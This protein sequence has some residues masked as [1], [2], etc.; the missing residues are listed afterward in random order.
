MN[1]HRR[2]HAAAHRR[3]RSSSAGARAR[4]RRSPAWSARSRGG[5]GAILAL[6]YLADPLSA[7]D[8]AFR[9]FVVLAGLI[10]AV[11]DRRVDRR[12]A[13]S[14]RRAAARATAC[15]GPP[16]G[17]PAPASAPSR[18]CSSCGSPAASWPKARCRAWPRRPADRRPSARWPRSCRPRPRSPSGS[19]AGSTTTGLPDVF[20]GF[21]PLPAAAGRPAGRPD[22]P[23]DRGGRRGQHAQG[24]GRDV[25]PVVGRDRVRRRATA[26]S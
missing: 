19:A 5:V 2:H 10:G 24:L 4:S 11:G 3:R 9:P 21:E 1:P 22:R 20:V 8:P 6:P 17:P 7:I 25:R 18:P 13:R 14:R 12:G 16:T 15:W 26:T 23:G